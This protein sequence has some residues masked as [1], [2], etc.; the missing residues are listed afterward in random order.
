MKNNYLFLLAYGLFF[1]G[2]PLFAQ[3]TVVFK[4]EEKKTG[5]SE[6]IN[7]ILRDYQPI[8]LNVSS[9]YEEIISLKKDESVFHF[10]FLYQDQVWQVKLSENKFWE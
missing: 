4:S 5:I 8:S 10:T 6:E 2:T 1:V 3:Q 7:Q 9:F